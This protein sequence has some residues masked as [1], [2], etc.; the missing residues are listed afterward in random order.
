MTKEELKELFKDN[1]LSDSKKISAAA[2]AN[3]MKWSIYEWMIRHWII[4]MK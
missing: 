4:T 2:L 3:I 1:K